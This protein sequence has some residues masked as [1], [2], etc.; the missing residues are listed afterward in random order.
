MRDKCIDAV[1]KAAGRALTQKELSDIENR[2]SRNKRQLAVKDRNAYLSMSPEQRLREAAK[3][4]S[5]EFKAEAAKKKQRVA[6]TIQAHDRISSYMDD[7][8]AVYGMGKMESLRRLLAFSSDG[9]SRVQSIETRS[10]AIAKDYIRQLVETFEA[11]EPRIFGLFDN[12]E[13]ERALTHEMFGQD[14]SAITTPEIAAIAKKAAQTWKDVAESAR[15]S[16]NESGGQIGKLE[17][18]GR[19]QNH[20]QYKTAKIGQDAW[21]KDHLTWIDRTRYVNEDG[22]PYDDA[23]MISFLEN[24]W[25][26]I[27]TGGANKVEPGKVAGKGMLASHNAEQRQIHY[28]NAESFLEHQKKYSETNAYTAMMR[29]I[30]GLSKDMAMID[31]LGPNPDASLDFWLETARK[32]DKLANPRKIGKVDQQADRTQNLYDYLAGKTKPV[33][34]EALSRTFDTMRNWMVATRLGSAWVTSITD[35]A[36][37]QLTAAVNNMSHVQLMRNQI[38]TMD[39]TNKTEKRMARRAGLSLNTLIGQMDRYGAEAMGPTFSAKVSSATM[40]ISGLNAATEARRRAFGVTMY[41]SIG[42]TVKDTKSWGSIDIHDKRLME[43]KG[44][45]ETDFSVWK[46]AKQEDWGGGNDTMLTPESIYKIPDSALAGLGDPKRL[47]REAALKLMGMV[48]EEVNMAVIEPGAIERSMIK[49]NLQ[50]GT[51]KGEILRSFFLFKTFPIAMISRHVGRGLGMETASGKAGYIA[52]LVA[53]TTILGAAAIQL[54]DMLG[55]KDPKDMTDWKFWMA[56]MAKG[57]ALGIYGDFLFD[58]NTQYGNTVL[59]TV[60]GPMAGMMEDLVDLTQGS[61]I[62]AAKGEK[63]DAG[64]KAIKFLKSNIPLQNLW[65]T[66]AITDRLIFNQLQEMVSPGYMRRVEQRAKRDFKQNYY[67]RPG[68]VTPDRGPNVERAVGEK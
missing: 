38:Q 34:S 7:Q 22:K 17:D 56:S 30:Q 53:S 51:W 36:T 60:A 59:G 40:R 46:Q 18:W 13:G 61:L 54:N 27:A 29:H 57:G 26:T 64:A 35:N 11:I 16:F 15:V 19:P 42:G 6:L 49:G 28:K 32:E 67:W 62:K 63:T 58:T 39:L 25:T 43:S 9:K 5:E 33:A 37:M 50:R 66:K 20:S 31:V 45:T 8:A 14:S 12:A 1:S 55:G 41:G 52:S 10:E 68:S 2:I 3:M 23:Q 21:V 47:R 4:A 48:D 44:V 65:Y 24:A